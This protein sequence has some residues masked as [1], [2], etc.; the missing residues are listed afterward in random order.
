MNWWHYEKAVAYYLKV[1][2]RNSLGGT[3]EDDEE[4]NSG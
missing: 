1:V 4:P 2:S 3:E